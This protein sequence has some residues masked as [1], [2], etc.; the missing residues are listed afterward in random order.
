MT[1][2]VIVFPD[3]K[4]VAIVYLRAQLAARSDTAEVGDR[5]KNPRAIRFVDV[6]RHGIGGRRQVVIE[7]ST[8]V[9][10]CWAA[11]SQDA[12]DLAQLCRGILN[13][14]QNTIQS[15]ATVYT[16]RDAELDDERDPLSDAPFS[17]FAIQIAMRGTAS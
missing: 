6:H 16:V 1:A 7:D 11:R 3:A 13:A 10:T 14:M 4:K 9:V 2:E 8:L 12:T 5:I 15:G 17:S